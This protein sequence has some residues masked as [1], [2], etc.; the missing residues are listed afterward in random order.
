PGK[1]IDLD[2]W[3][4]FDLESDP[5]EAH[6]LAHDHPVKLGELIQAFEADA[7]ANYVYPIDNR[8]HRRVLA[9]PPFMEPTLSVPRIFYPGCSTVPATV[10]TSLLSD[11]D[12]AI[13]CDFE[14]RRADRG[15]LFAVGNSFGGMS[16]YVDGDYLHFVY[17]GG[18]RLACAG[19]IRLSQGK[20]HVLLQHRALGQRQG[21]G[22]L[23]VNGQEAPTLIDMSPTI[24][25]LTGEGLDVGRD[26]RLKVCDHYSGEGA[27][28]YSGTIRHVRLQPG[29]R[30]PD[31]I[32]NKPERQAQLD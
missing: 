27:F 9:I 14:F 16:L 6:D 22:T 12:F 31:S 23:T 20:V 4:L 8:D 11:R 24:L 18:K 2:N 25:R 26:R 7:Q 29:S 3:M 19:A 17:N 30:A 32:S 5:T 10:M 21:Q 28:A 13:E 1:V 15:V